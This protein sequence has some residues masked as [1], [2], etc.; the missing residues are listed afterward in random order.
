MTAKY[1]LVILAAVC[2]LL[3]A[4]GIATGRVSVLALGLLFWLASGNL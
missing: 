2:F 4:L 1:A 3:A